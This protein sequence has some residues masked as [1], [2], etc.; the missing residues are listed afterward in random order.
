MNNLNSRLNIY[1]TI[2]YLMLNI[3]SIIILY[4]NKIILIFQQTRHIFR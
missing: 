1:V 2:K 4:I 3:I